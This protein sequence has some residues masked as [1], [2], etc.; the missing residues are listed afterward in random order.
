MYFKELKEFECILHG[1]GAAF[2]NLGIIELNESFGFCFANWLYEYKGV[3]GS[4]GWAYA[5]DSLSRRSGEEAEIVFFR[6]VRI[7]LDQWGVD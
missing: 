7:F 3:S 2:Q 6:L 4:A 1:H 5:I